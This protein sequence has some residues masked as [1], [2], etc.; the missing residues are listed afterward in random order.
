MNNKIITSFLVVLLT[1]S[2]S[3]FSY[4]L[5]A[6]NS[7]IIESTNSNSSYNAT[8]PE[9]EY[10]DE[11]SSY[12]L[13]SESGVGAYSSSSS[14]P[15]LLPVTY[16]LRTLGRVSPVKDQGPIGTCWIF[17]SYGSLESYL[18]P[19][20]TWDFSENHVKNILS[21]LYPEGFD[22]DYDDGGFMIMVLAYLARWSGPVNES[23]DP[24]NPNSGISPERLTP[25]KHVQEAVFIP[26]RESPLDNDQFKQAIMNYGA[27][28]T[29]MCW[30]NSYYNPATYSYYLN[31]YQSLNHAISLVGWDD[32]YDKNNFRIPAPGNGA[33]IVRN[34]WGTDWP[35]DDGYFYMS[36]YDLLLGNT[37]DDPYYSANIAFMN[38]ESPNNYKQIYQYD[39][40]GLVS[41]ISS[42]T[43]G[44]STAE[45][46]NVF[47]ATSSNP[48]TA[49]SFYALAPHTSYQIYTIVNNQTTLVAEGVT[50]TAGYKTIK[51]NQPIPLIAGQEFKIMV[52]V[53]TPGYDRPIA[54]EYA[55]WYWS[56]SKAT[57]NPG[58]SFIKYDG[59]WTDLNN[60]VFSDYP[61]A[62]V[63]LKAFTATAGNLTL[64]FESSN[65]NPVVGELLKFTINAMNSGPDNSLGT[66]VK[67]KL[68]EG[69]KFSSY[70]ASMGIYNP[71]TGIWTIVELPVGEKATLNI[72]TWANIPGYMVNKATIS[73]L[74]YNNNPVSSTMIVLQIK[75]IINHLSNKNPLAN[76]YEGVYTVSGESTPL[77]SSELS[78]NSNNPLS[79]KNNTNYELPLFVI[80]IFL[81]FSIFVY[82][83]MSVK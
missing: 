77:G 42:S 48:L 41:D 83:F 51:F 70:L 50:K 46:M 36:Y 1:L 20:E 73:S 47:N 29:A 56:T 64:Q 67:Y 4:A 69:L 58:E 22:R 5:G 71:D 54:I 23:D 11:K 39:P 33:F 28:C 38:A 26:N 6:D 18:N 24:Y 9:S 49:A 62:N 19:N 43:T 40:F 78:D 13:N 3:G 25:I 55:D 81:I 7:T 37:Y 32:N 16:D 8:P 60:T 31:K 15:A 79:K 35:S 12:S 57:A 72:Y 14:P 80:S 52:K 27:V 75:A 76:T 65:L 59:V 45:F 2:F 68:P 66:Q 10:V 53:N 44:C 34:S 17:S 63:C 74:T 30:D 21:N 61:H 82:R